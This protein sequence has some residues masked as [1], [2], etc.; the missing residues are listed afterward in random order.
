MTNHIFTKAIHLMD[1]IYSKEDNRSRFQKRI[2]CDVFLTVSLLI[3]IINIITH[4]YIYAIVTLSYGLFCLLCALAFRHYKST[5]LTTIIINVGSLLML[6]YL[7][8]FGIG[9]IYTVLWIIM[10]PNVTTMVLNLKK[11]V[12]FLFSIF[13]LIMVLYLTPLCDV[14][15]IQFHEYFTKWYVI[16]I[17]SVFAAIACTFEYLRN[18]T[19]M[20]LEESRKE[21]LRLSYYD[22]LTQIYNR[23]SFDKSLTEVFTAPFSAKRRVALLMIDIDNFKLYNDNYGH[24]QG[25]KILTKIAQTINSYITEDTYTFARY[26]GE[27]FVILMPDADNMI[28]VALADQI[29]TAVREL[30]LVYYDSTK[31]ASEYLSISIGVACEELSNLD[32]SETLI[33]LADENLYRA[34]SQGKNIVCSS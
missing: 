9:N 24:L 4:E 6:L 7:L 25:D 33:R 31:A 2:L 1:N 27:E 11:A 30:G 23:R 29:K 17:Y 22:D 34:K 28:A 5:A 3:G 18:I 14:L 19:S 10:I 21:I 15:S 16:L 32:G 13:V 12:I 8:L 26:G 20:K